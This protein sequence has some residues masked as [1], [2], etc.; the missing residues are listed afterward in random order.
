MEEWH[1][2]LPGLYDTGL[3]LG[4]IMEAASKEGSGVKGQ[5][6]TKVRV[7]WQHQQQVWVSKGWRCSL[8]PF[9]AAPPPASRT[10]ICWPVGENKM[11]RE[12]E[13]KQFYTQRP[14]VKRKVQQKHT[15]YYLVHLNKLNLK[16]AGGQCKL[17]Y[18]TSN[19]LVSHK[20]QIRPKGWD[21]T[22]T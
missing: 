9:P 4:G 13:K 14:L 17:L 15:Q 1:L 2:Q 5:C 22:K 10:G 11:C 16:K 18:T 7:H 3:W 20:A 19:T 6:G 12:D 21:D 8:K